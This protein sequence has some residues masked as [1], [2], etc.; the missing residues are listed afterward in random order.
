MNILWRYTL[1][2]DTAIQ[3]A[4]AFIG[5]RVYVVAGPDLI[6]L[7]AAWGYHYSVV[8]LFGPLIFRI[9]HP[10]GWL[11]KFMASD[12]MLLFLGK[13]RWG[14]LSPLVYDPRIREFVDGD[15]SP[16][17]RK[18]KYIFAGDYKITR[19]FSEDTRFEGLIA[20]TH[21]KGET[22]WNSLDKIRP[23][24]R[25]T[26]I[27]GDVLQVESRVIMCQN[28]FGRRSMMPTGCS[29]VCFD[30]HTGEILWKQE[31]YSYGQRLYPGVETNGVLTI[32]GGD[33]RAGFIRRI[34]LMTGKVIS[35]ETGT[36]PFSG[37]AADS[38]VYYF[39]MGRDVVAV[40][41]EDL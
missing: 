15:P 22:L 4:P 28:Y 27:V 34:D 37:L 32:T 31:S 3:Y 41:E 17:L 7:D 12:G 30:R 5:G 13:N 2:T 26:R 39:G 16:I 19:F 40:R 11:S 33:Q 14:I 6:S 21:P 23:A 24:V 36:A 25:S 35:Q 10:V 9:A 1:K 18:L 20:T 8:P 38:G 29:I